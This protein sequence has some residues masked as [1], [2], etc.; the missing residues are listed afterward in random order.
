MPGA[1]EFGGRPSSRKASKV[2]YIR[3]GSA[4]YSVPSRPIGW[5]V[6]IAV[7]GRAIRRPQPFNEHQLGAPGEVSI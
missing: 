3:F 5:T 7:S 1:A 6:P 2:S 4:R